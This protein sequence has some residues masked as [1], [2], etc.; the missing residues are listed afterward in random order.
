MYLTQNTQSW[1]KPGEYIG[2]LWVW[3]S[4][5]RLSNYLVSCYNF[6]FIYLKVK[7]NFKWVLIMDT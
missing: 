3:L 6:V 4:M 2:F 5:Y 7:S 1:I